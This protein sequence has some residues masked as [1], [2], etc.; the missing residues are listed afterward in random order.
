MPRSQLRVDTLRR[1][2]P[3]V[4]MVPTRVALAL[5]VLALLA[6]TIPI[7][8]G[9][10]RAQ[11]VS[12]AEDGVEQAR[13]QVDDAYDVVS[14]AV[15]DRDAVEGELFDALKR[16]DRAVRAVAEA[17]GRLDTVAQALARAEAGAAGVSEALRDQA[18][19]AYVEAV[20]NPASMVVVSDDVET[21]MVMG[22]ALGE[23]QTRQRQELVGLAAQQAELERLRTEYEAERAE[24][25]SMESE[26]AEETA[27]LEDVF[28]RADDAV[29]AAYQEAAAADS[30]YR[31]AL[32]DVERVRAAATTTTSQPEPQPD[33]EA[34]EGPSAADENDPPTT[35]TSAGT[36]ATTD[37]DQVGTPDTTAPPAPSPARERPTVSPSAE[38]WRSLVAAYFPGSM[39]EDALVIIQCESH[40][41]PDAVNPY[42]GASGLFQF[43]P[44]TWAVAS[45]SAGVGGASVFDPEANIAAAAW[46]TGYYQSNGDDPWAA[47]T[48]REHL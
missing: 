1:Y 4:T 40:G 19:Q 3:S 21:A 38:R 22:Q 20:T 12:E 27:H 41:D 14:E 30:A 24:V 33:S 6:V 42:S 47:W 48:C 37:G 45:V 5:S 25:S 44:G 31:Q 23:D 39:V 18:V 16:Y 26:L 36:T 35:T 46:M 34:P 13:R 28:A 15:A 7:G 9:T 11:T 29:A 10:A 17:N 32:S 2:A 8:V 43:I